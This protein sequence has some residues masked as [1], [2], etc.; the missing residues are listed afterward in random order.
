MKKSSSYH[1]KKSDLLM[2]QNTLITVNSIGIK[3]FIKN[4]EMVTNKFSGNICIAIY[5][6][7]PLRKALYLNKLQKLKSN[8]K[9]LFINPNY[10]KFIIIRIKTIYLFILVKSAKFLF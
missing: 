9:V 2:F 3:S 8:M 1:K 6:L 5:Y 4:L 7:L 10:Y